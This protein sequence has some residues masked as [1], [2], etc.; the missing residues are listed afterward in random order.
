MKVIASLGLLILVTSMIFGNPVFA[1]PFDI[2]KISISNYDSNSA[3]VK[4]SWN[5]DDQAT[6]YK[7][8]CVSCKPNTAEFTT[9]DSITFNNV[10]PFPNSSFAML[11]M[12]IYDSENEI[13]TAKQLIID[14]SQ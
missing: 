2:I 14:L 3:T 7:I 13:I 6:N 12:I 4:I 10:T 8:G 9:G 11:Y 1:E 5:H